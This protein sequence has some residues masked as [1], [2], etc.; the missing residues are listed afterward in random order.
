VKDS[1]AVERGE[2]RLQ[3][4]ARC[5]DQEALVADMETRVARPGEI[6]ARDVDDAARKLKRT[7]LIQEIH[8]AVD[9]C[10]ADTQASAGILEPAAVHDAEKLRT[11]GALTGENGPAMN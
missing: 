4:L 3:V 6:A 10:V 11:N 8:N 5:Q 1:A 2:P 7:G 9:S